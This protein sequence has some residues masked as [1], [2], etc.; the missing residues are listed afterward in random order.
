MTFVA[1]PY[2]RFAD[3]LITAL[4]GGM[5]REE[6]QFTGTEESYS[7]ASPG[8][9]AATVKVFGQRNDSFA[10]FEGG[11]DYDYQDE[12]GLIVWKE[13]GRLPDDHSFFYVNYYLREGRR[14][15]TDR[16]PGSVTTTLAESFAR[17]FAVLHKQMEMIYRSA[18]IDLATGASL[19][20][21]SALLAVARKD[22]RFAGGEALFKRSTP[23]E[24]DI[25]IPAGALV[26]TNQGQNFETSDKRTLR[27]GQLSVVA[28]IRAQVEGPAGR[29]EAGEIKNIN[30]PIFGIESVINEAATFFATEKE[31]DEELRR[32]IKGTLER[33]GKST[34]NAIKYSLIEEI[35]GVNE[36]NVQ[37]SETAEPG[38]VEIKF[39]LGAAV[40]PDLVRRIEETIFNSRAAGVRVTHNLPTR[41]APQSGLPS[42]PGGTLQS[43]VTNHFAGRGEP[44]PALH[45]TPDLLNRMPEG[46]LELQIEILLRLT[47]PNLSASQ[48]E[49]IEDEV[50]TR[51]VDFI[52][53][54]PM[55]ADLVY[56]KLLG[57]IVEPEEVGDAILLIRTAP[58]VGA[59]DGEVHKGNLATDGRKARVE[60]RRVFVGLMGEAIFIDLQ[61]LLEQKPQATA[62]ASITPPIETAINDAIRGALATTREKLS[63][64]ALRVAIGEA[65][66]DAGLQF[67]ADNAVVINAEY[68]E[69]GRLLNNTEEVPVEE[70]QVLNLRKVEIRMKEALDG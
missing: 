24:G 61:V 50:R 36:G 48:K 42:S 59:P 30:R 21:V 45:V 22:A 2:E 38:K 44:V 4:T 68:E 6:H 34:L 18:F 37:L 66:A 7:L 13:K 29:V 64:A 15:L 33:A 20:H 8:A 67:I 56:N 46:V 5:I 17:E 1:Q 55:G 27:R 14:R 40:D 11:I 43:D 9:L 32:R 23:A 12:E 65:I 28:P 19:D 3:D 70:H 62:V 52:E 57:R 58:I 35:P 54:L 47:E 16:N 41:S 39:G 26:S 10:L 53:A 63:K 60:S 25:T 49:S 51:V 69:T 31:T